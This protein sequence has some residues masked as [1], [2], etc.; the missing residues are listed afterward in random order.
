MIEEKA[1]VQ[2]EEESLLRDVHSKALLNK[3]VYALNEY[4]LRKNIAKQKKQ[5]E[6]EVEN[7][8]QN[9]ENN[10]QEIKNLL[11]ELVRKQ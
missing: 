6:Q 1:L 4:Q 5:K 8:I 10:M 7:R 9:L 11:I 2:T 3:D